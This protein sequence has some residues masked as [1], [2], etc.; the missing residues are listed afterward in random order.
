MPEHKLNMNAAEEIV[1]LDDTGPEV[2]VD[3]DEGEALPINPQQPVK[4]VLGDEG[5]AEVIPEPETEEAKADDH[6]EYS[7][8]VKKRIDKLTAKLRE[9]ERREQAATQFAQNVKKE[10]E[11]LTQQKTNLDSNYIVAE[12]NR[13]TAETEGT[14]NILR[15]A[16]EEGEIDAQ[17]NAQQ[18]LAAL[19]VEAQRVQALNQER[20]ALAAQPQVT[21]EIPRAPEPQPQEYS[22][23]DP[24]AQEWAEENPWFGNDKAMT[25]TSFA[26]HEDLLNEGFDPA[27]NEYYD[28]INNRIRKEFPHK[29]NEEIQ[30]SQPAQ[31]VAPAKRSAKTGRKTVRLTPSQVAIANK[32]GVPLEEYAKYVE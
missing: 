28:E 18:K 22:E 1:Q 20:T 21:Q 5:A 8:G 6:E 9:A 4:P 14:K 24:R 23:P 16:N 31:T 26:F 15:K 13:I 19:A 27:S 25:M 3:I 17:T 7:K 12:A 11:T 32:L 10:N 30:T 29:F 2:D